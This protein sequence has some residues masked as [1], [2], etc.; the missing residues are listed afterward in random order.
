M[1]KLGIA[2]ATVL[3][4]ASPALAQSDTGSRIEAHLGWDH[5]AVPDLSSQTGGQSPASRLL[6]GV[7][8][9]YDVN[10]GHNLVAGIDS[11]FDLGGAT[12]CE[13]P[14]EGALDSLC[15]KMVRDWDIGARLGLRTG[16]GLVYGR[17]AYD[18]SLVRSSYLP[19][20]GTSRTVSDDFGG[21]RLGVGA[22]LPVTSSTF[23][24]AEYRYTTTPALP[25]QNQLLAG[26]G[27]HF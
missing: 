22:Q 8:L 13:G 12:R 15:G 20:D 16:L 19:G 21:L 7:G 1:K 9:G 24:K 4:A 23:V 3:A 18:N 5:L 6:Y 11:D 26:I 10:L 2:I 25:D 27:I 17:V 14:T